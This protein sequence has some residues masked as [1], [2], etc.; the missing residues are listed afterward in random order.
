MRRVTSLALCLIAGIG[1][2]AAA[3]ATTEGAQA[4]AETFHR[5]LG[6]T[7]AGQPDFV[8]I[9]PQGD[10]YRVTLD[11][12]EFTRP[13][14]PVGFTLDSA[15]LSFLT[16]QLPD[17]TWHVS[18]MQLP[19]PLTLHIQEQ[20]MTYRFDGFSFDG[21]Y[22][23]ALAA[24]S[25]FDEKIGGM[26]TEAKQLNGESTTTYREQTVTGTGT[27]SGADGVD[28]TVQQTVGGVSGHMSATP[29]SSEGAPPSPQFDVTYG[30]D[31]GSGDVTI[32][33]LKGVKVLDLW[34]YV[35]AHV[36]SDAQAID[37]A[38]LK[39]LLTELLPVF[40]RLDEKGTVHALSATTP[41]GEFGM[42]EFSGSLGLS[43]IVSSSELQAS[44]KLA[45]PSYPHEL[46]PAWATQLIPDA[47]EV[48][49]DFTGLNLDASARQVIAEIDVTKKPWVDDS[50]W[51]VAGQLAVPEAGVKFKLG[52]A[53]VHGPV[54]NIEAEGEVTFTKQIPTG[55]FNVTAKGIDA[56]IAL[57]KSAGG[58]PM[59]SQALASLTLLQSWG[60]QTSDGST[61]FG[62]ELRDD[63]E[64]T[65]NGQMIRP[66]TGKAL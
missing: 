56:A 44:T 33:G 8:R 18:D 6:P 4:L 66:A 27:A 30:V 59:A 38:E 51:T 54:L 47:I 25:R 35:V 29:P 21:V 10:A 3:S 32:A 7:R 16:Q 45:G 11:L 12:D 61:Y 31:S 57:L 48:G 41:L 60:R 62:I 22:D 20:A 1:Q 26:S 63:G 50:A 65:V 55:S 9:E 64:I 40:Q 52:P 53:S 17:A 34:A 36:Q 2:A 15:E 24:F 13:L 49:I 28:I 58:D 42:Q 43:G 14:E 5:Y 39:R 19:T 46:V 23:P 37:N